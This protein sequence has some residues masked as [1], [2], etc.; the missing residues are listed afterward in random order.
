MD[1]SRGMKSRDKIT[2]AD[3]K[4]MYKEVVWEHN[5]QSIILP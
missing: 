4:D 3:L 2:Q 1:R 5:I